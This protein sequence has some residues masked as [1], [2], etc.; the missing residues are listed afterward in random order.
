MF[1]SSSR[2][3]Q[4]ADQAY[5]HGGMAEHPGDGQLRNRPAVIGSENLELLDDPVIRDN[6]DENA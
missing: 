4:H 5:G 6:Q 2:S 3:L 1:S